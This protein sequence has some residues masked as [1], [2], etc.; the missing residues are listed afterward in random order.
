M[1]YQGTS[2]RTAFAAI[3]CTLAMSTVFVLGSVGPA[4]A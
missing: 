4:I 2:Y 1:T 3:L